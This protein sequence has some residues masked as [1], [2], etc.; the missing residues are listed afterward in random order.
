MNYLPFIL[1][2]LVVCIALGLFLVVR[3]LTKG[4]ANVDDRLAQ[5]T[6]GSTAAQATPDLRARV[7]AAV[8]KTERGSRIGRD[9]ARADL[10][11][12]AGEFVLLKLAGAVV[13]AGVA[14]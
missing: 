1:L 10:K 11:L 13:M 3:M 2:G 5:F 4:S 14:A 8:T 7:D 9:L 12:T 6:G